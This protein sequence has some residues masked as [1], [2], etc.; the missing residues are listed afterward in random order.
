MNAVTVVATAKKY[1]GETETP[2]NS[3]FKDADF[4]KRMEQVGWVKGA[5]WCTYFGELVCK[6]AYAG[7]LDIIV[8]LNKLFDGSA[9]ATYK[10]FELDKSGKFSVGQIPKPGALAVWRFGVDWRG[11]FGIVEV[12]NVNQNDF[13]SIEGN[14][15]DDGS[16]EGYEVARRNRKAKKPFTAKGLNLVGF[17]YLPQLT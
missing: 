4:Q 9:T 1:L 11:H 13:A 6:E 3:G 14:T 7:N 12:V 15:N 8:L 16:R 10:K 17:I 5:A 2:N